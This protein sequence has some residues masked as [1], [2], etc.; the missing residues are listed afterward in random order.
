MVYLG[1]LKYDW[2]LDQVSRFGVWVYDSYKT[3]YGKSNVKQED[4]RYTMIMKGNT[5]MFETYMDLSN[6][7]VCTN[8]VLWAID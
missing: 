3:M 1:I 6:N 4:E 5:R 7:N 2:L 8:D